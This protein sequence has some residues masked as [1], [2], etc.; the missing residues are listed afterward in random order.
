MRRWS[1]PWE[2]KSDRNTVTWHQ[3]RITSK[4]PTA[5]MNIAQ[6]IVSRNDRSQSTTPGLTLQS[7]FS[8][9]KSFFLLFAVLFWSAVDSMYQS[10]VTSQDGLA[11]AIQLLSCRPSRAYQPPVGQSLVEERTAQDTSV[12]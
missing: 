10:S 12:N 9:T 11:E 4:V 1:M 5:S 2:S 3:T 6:S 7:D 8:R